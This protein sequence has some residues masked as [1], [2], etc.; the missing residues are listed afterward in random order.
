MLRAAYAHFAAWSLLYCT[1]IAIAPAQTVHG[2][3]RDASRIPAA[4]T[5]EQK[6]SNGSVELLEPLLKQFVDAL[7]VV[8]AEA[9]D[10][11]PIDK[12][13]YEGAIPAM[14]RKLDPHTQFFDPQQFEQLKEMERSEQKG[15]GS[16][17]SV[18]P[19]QV[20]FLQ[21]LPGTPS[22]RAGIMPGDELLAVN[23]VP[24]RNLEPEQIIGLLSEARQQT[25]TIYVRRQGAQR[26]LA[27]TLTPALVDSP[28]VDRAFL[29]RP[30]YA[31]I[32]ITSWDMQT[33]QQ[34]TDALTKV[35][36][37]KL[38]AVILDLRNNPG[39]VVKAALD[40]AAMFLKPGQRIL[41]ARGRFGQPET[42]DVPK[43]ASPYR[44]RMAVIIN[45]KTASAS[46]ILTGALQDHD[47][48]VVV[49]EPSYGKGLVQSVLPL[50]NNTGLAL[51]TAFYYT[52]SGRSIQKPLRNSQLSETFANKTDEP[53]PTFKTDA[54]RTVRGGGGIQPDISVYP[55]ERTRLETVLDASGAPTAFATQYLSTHSPLPPNFDITPDL[56][57]EFKVFL[58]ARSIQPNVGEWSRERSWISNRL[59]QEIV[60]QAS[61]VAAGDEIE[62]QRDPQVQEALR[63]VQQQSIAVLRPGDRQQH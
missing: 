37:D 25:V 60:T 8:D 2:P 50:S 61:G 19:G 26:P 38:E 62:M 40:A 32:R 21:T 12:L 44:F 9:A 35:G 31:Y 55:P 22:N 30:G 33:S 17:V 56:L 42:A 43:A 51:T 47:R 53:K 1:A 34:L 41:T 20:I 57:D 36:G 10:K 5:A 54:G 59:K 27:F 49:G 46:E 58:S 63:T 28:T 45:G 11:A 48:A 6:S 3:D 16:I 24:I 39:G 14:L 29:L 13:V 7:T 23:N 18:L 4:G 52:P 15:F